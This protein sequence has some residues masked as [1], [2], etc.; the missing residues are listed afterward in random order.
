MDVTFQ[1]ITTNAPESRIRLLMKKRGEASLMIGYLRKIEKAVVADGLDYEAPLLRRVLAKKEWLQRFVVGVSYRVP[2]IAPKT[3]EKR[4]KIAKR[5]SIAAENRA[6]ALEV[7]RKKVEKMVKYKDLYAKAKDSPITAPLDPIQEVRKMTFARDG[8]KCVRCGRTDQLSFDHI[9][10]KWRGGLWSTS[11]GQTLCIPCNSA[12]GGYAIS[13][14][15]PQV[16]IDPS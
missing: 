9:I 8:Y 14:L 11:N 13:F 2:H 16:P 5:E 12:K 10:P 7:R 6:I 15:P 1:N 3:K 4:A